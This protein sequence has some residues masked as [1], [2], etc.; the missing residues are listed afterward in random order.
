MKP[1]C[2]IVSTKQGTVSHVGVPQDYNPGY[3]LSHAP[4][5]FQPSKI[6]SQVGPAT[7]RA[8][9]LPPANPRQG[10]KYFP[11]WPSLQLKRPPDPNALSLVLENPIFGATSHWL[12]W[13]KRKIRAA[14]FESPL[15]SL[16]QRPTEP[17]A[18]SP[19]NGPVFCP[20]PAGVQSSLGG[21]GI[22]P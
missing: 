5:V 18:T 6:S 21:T 22:L 1:T 11:P 13:A 20:A 7:P 8:L 3:R 2:P 4:Y 16:N 12:T 17:P 14:Q 15:L 10:P 9:G 19:G